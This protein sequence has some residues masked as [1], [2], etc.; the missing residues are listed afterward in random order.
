M[1]LLLTHN[2]KK[3]PFRWLFCIVTELNFVMFISGF[4]Y[5]HIFK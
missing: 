5:V 2:T 4:F 3:P 1:G